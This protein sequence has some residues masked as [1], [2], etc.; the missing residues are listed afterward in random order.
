[1]FTR[2]EGVVQWKGNVVGG[3]EGVMQC[4]QGLREIYTILQGMI[5][6]ERLRFLVDAMRALSASSPFLNASAHIA[7][8]FRLA[9]IEARM[10]GE[11]VVDDNVTALLG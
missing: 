2:I 6:F 10:G 3:H 8:D 4:K 1:M 11:G 5:I 7:L 9:Y